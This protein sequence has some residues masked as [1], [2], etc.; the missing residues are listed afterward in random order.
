MSDTCSLYPLFGDLGLP[1]CYPLTG[2]RNAPGMQNIK[3][4]LPNGQQPT[5]FLCPWDF[6]GKNIGV[7]CH[8]LL[9]EIFPTQGLNPGLPC[10]MQ[11][12]YHLSHQ[13]S[14]GLKLAGKQVPENL[15]TKMVSVSRISKHFSISHCTESLKTYSHNKHPLPTT[16]EMTLY[17]DITRRSTPKSDGLYSLQS[18]MEKLYTVS[19]NKTRS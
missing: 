14:P 19:K 12:L 1:A 3:P 13:G 11:M 9:Q 8:F 6:P 10:C 2:I 7:G 15:F 4:L 5:T 18:K 17:M 16:Q